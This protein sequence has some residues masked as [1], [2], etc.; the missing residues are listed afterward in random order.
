MPSNFVDHGSTSPCID[1]VYVAT[2][3]HTTMLASEVGGQWSQEAM[4][5]RLADRDRADGLRDLRYTLAT[6]RAKSRVPSKETPW[7]K[8]RSPYD[9]KARERLVK[10]AGAFGARNK[11]VI[12]ITSPAAKALKPSWPLP[13]HVGPPELPGKREVSDYKCHRQHAM[14]WRENSM[15]GYWLAVPP[16]PSSGAATGEERQQ[17]FSRTCPARVRNR[18]ASALRYI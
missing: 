12:D 1:A 13:Q 6:R 16:N 8:N 5:Q 18:P 10:G 14:L 9:G 3:I 2:H 7:W 4:K 11:L 17:K 15:T